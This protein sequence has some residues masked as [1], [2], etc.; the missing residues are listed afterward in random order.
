MDGINLEKGLSE[1]LQRAKEA[2]SSDSGYAEEIAR[3]A[4]LLRGSAEPHS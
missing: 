1:F 2:F 3:E 4:M